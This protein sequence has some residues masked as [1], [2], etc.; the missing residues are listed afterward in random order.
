MALAY[1][2]SKLAELRGKRRLDGRGFIRAKER[3]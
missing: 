2:L 1:E 3:C